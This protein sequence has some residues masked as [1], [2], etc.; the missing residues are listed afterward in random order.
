[1]N[2][3]LIRAFFIGSSLPVYLP[4]LLVVSH[5]PSGQRNYSLATYALVAWLYLGSLNVIGSLISIHY[6][7]GRMTRFVLTGCVS[8][9]IVAIF[10]TLNHSYNFTN[11]RERFMYYLGL[12]VMHLL[13]FTVTVNGLDYFFG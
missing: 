12:L 11:Q 8:A 10:V 9:L 2:H 4:F 7:L 13:T 6:Q 3:H 1:M 5:I